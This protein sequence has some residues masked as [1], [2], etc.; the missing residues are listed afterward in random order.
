MASRIAWEMIVLPICHR[1]SVLMSLPMS[2][3]HVD[4]CDRKDHVQPSYLKRRGG[5]NQ[6]WSFYD[7]HDGKRCP[8]NAIDV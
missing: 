8:K 5:P 4:I 2:C 7:E 3:E 1:L 6:Y